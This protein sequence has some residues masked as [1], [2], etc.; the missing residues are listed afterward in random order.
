[1]SVAGIIFS[2]I[3]DSNIADLTRLRTIASVPFGC[4]YRLIDFTL[5]NMVNSGITNV[6]VIT[7]YNYH[8]LMDHIGS[9]KDWD[10]ARAR[11]GIK[12]LPPF[13]SAFAN[14]INVLYKTRL[15]ALKSINH[16]IS[17]IKDDYVVLSDCDVICNIDLNEIISDH[18]KSGAD[19]TIAV[20][21]MYLTPDSARINIIYKIDEDGIIH[22]V[23]SYPAN[24]EGE[25]DVS[26]NIVV[27]S[28]RYLQTMVLDAIAHDYVSMN[29]DIIARNVRH[30]Y[31]RVYRY[32][33]YFAVISSMQD[34]F[35]HSMELISDASVRREL[36]GVKNRPIYTKIRNSAPTR[37]IGDA[38]VRNSLVADGCVIEGRVENSM[39]FRGVRIGK[40]T[41]VKNSIL[42]Q[43]TYTGENVSLNC[44]LTDK[45]VVIRD[46]V[47]L[48]GHTSM[49]IY[50]EKGR[51]I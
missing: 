19:M 36:F 41:T 1:M 9:G 35:K 39:L 32:D 51:M 3:H 42:F 22:D 21:R 45:D 30:S 46:N 2:N 18:I 49:P 26:L 20:K 33:G 13:I 11:G 40:N 7:H 5:S 48:S 17:N 28:R 29:R 15:E 50:V 4:R 8:S 24:F 44:V 25:A 10:L 27:M 12:I 47:N 23:E 6:N 31:F 16:A 34:Y 14:N 43:D 37:Y 38:S